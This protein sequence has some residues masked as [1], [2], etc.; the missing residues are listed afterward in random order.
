TTVKPGFVRTRMTADMDL[1]GPLTATP[2]E[3]ARRVVALE[4]RP[5]DVIHVLRV[6]RPVMLVIRAI[7]EAIFKK[8]RL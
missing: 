5:A 7:P 1:P 2:A 3:V 4:R 8:L 6:W